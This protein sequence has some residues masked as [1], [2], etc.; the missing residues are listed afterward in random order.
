MSILSHIMIDI[1]VLV[2]GFGVRD[3][4]LWFE[5][6]QGTATQALEGH[7]QS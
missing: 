3:F 2:N 1:L 5:A 4:F 6:A 7:P